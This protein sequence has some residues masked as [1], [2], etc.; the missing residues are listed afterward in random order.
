MKYIFYLIVRL[1]Y[2]SYRF[3]YFGLENLDKILKNESL[4]FC[5]ASWHEHALAGVTGQKNV[6]YC[7]II[8]QSKDGE[9]VNYISKKFGFSV[10]RGSSSRGGKEARDFLLKHLN[11]RSCL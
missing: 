5:L 2:A 10:A 11:R 4:K 3:H 1:L 7:F 6:P 9:F 8:S